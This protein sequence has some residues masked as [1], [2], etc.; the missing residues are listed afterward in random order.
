MPRKKEVDMKMIIAVLV[1]RAIISMF[2]KEKKV[3]TENNDNRIRVIHPA[4]FE[5]R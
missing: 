3:N 5:I 2:E 4:E 1:V